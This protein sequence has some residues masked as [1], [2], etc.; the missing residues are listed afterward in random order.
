MRVA[1][2]ISQVRELQAAGNSFN[3]RSAKTARKQERVAKARVSVLF[4]QGMKD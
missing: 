1:S 4:Q 3:Y 2:S